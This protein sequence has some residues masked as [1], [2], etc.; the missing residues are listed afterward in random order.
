MI[1]AEYE[2][3]FEALLRYSYAST[4]IESEK[5][6]KFMKRLDVLLQHD[7]TQMV[8]LGASFYSKMEHDKMDNILFELLREDPRGCTITVSSELTHLKVEI[9]EVYVSIMADSCRQ[10]C[11][12]QVESLL[13]QHLCMAVLALSSLSLLS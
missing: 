2:E 11:T 5:I 1:I 9:L 10:P 4:V 12:V 8:V 6:P 3:H 13:V 7:T